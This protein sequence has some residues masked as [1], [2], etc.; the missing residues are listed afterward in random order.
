MDLDNQLETS[1]RAFKKNKKNYM[2][3][4]LSMFADEQNIIF[5]WSNPTYLYSIVN[6]MVI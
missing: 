3:L 4:Q 6:M 5:V 1:L 2:V